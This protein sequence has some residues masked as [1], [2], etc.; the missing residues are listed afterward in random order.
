MKI[1]KRIAVSAIFLICSNPFILYS[2]EPI[3]VGLNSI[4]SEDIIQTIGYLS[5][6]RFKGRLPGTAEYDQAARYFGTR[7]KNAGLK[8]IGQQSMLHYFNDEVNIINEAQLLLLSA[9]KRSFH[10]FNLGQDFICRGFTGSGT[11]KAEVVFA[12]FGMRTDEYSDYSN[13]DVK[14][15]IVMVYKSA[16]PWVSK[17]GSWGDISPRAKARIAQQLGASAII[18]IA[19]PQ[20][21]PKTMIYGSIACGN[22]PHLSDFPMLQVGLNVSDSLFLGLPHKPD[23]LYYLIVDSRTPQSIYTGR[24]LMINVKTDYIAEK[25]TANVVGY[26]EGV[27][28][29]LKDEYVIIGAHLDHVGYQTESLFF[30]GANDNASGVATLIAIAEAIKKSEVKPKR[31]ILIVAFSSEE[32]GL[33]GSKYF[34]ANSPVDLSKVVAM[35][36]FDCV[37]QGDSI[38]IGGRLSY[39]KLWTKAKRFDKKYTKLLSKKSFGGGGADAEAFYS[40]GIPTLYFNTTNGYR[41][42]HQNLDKAETINSELVEKVAQLG[43]LMTVELANGKYNGEKDRLKK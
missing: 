40:A 39:P 20:I 25:P 32:S 12:G 5:S 42:L 43:F 24:S 31:S 26:I 1:S 16:P 10:R 38:S 34:V 13:V 7:I 9:D 21:F 17:N 23:E 8:P 36:N 2:Q 37:G 14:D 29:K 41:Y 27:D 15:K 33:K 30:P 6:S 3:E 22:T 19:D 18:F 4:N 35:M 11:V 28:P